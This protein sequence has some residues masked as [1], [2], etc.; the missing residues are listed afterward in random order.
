MLFRCLNFTSVITLKE[1]N[2]ISTRIN[3]IRAVRGCTAKPTNKIY[4]KLAFMRKLKLKMSNIL[5]NENLLS[6]FKLSVQNSVIDWFFLSLRIV[7]WGFITLN[8]ETV[9][10]VAS[11]PDFSDS[12]MRTAE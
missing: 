8:F 5:L 11:R 3:K 9:F 1:M 12:T 7:A 4:I 2:P 6:I 10:F